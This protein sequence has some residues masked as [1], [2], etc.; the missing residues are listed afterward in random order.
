MG[1]A[2]AD[3]TL[4]CESKFASS[5]ASACKQIWAR[6]AGGEWVQMTRGLIKATHVMHVTPIDADAPSLHELEVIQHNPIQ[7]CPLVRRVC[8]CVCV[9][10]RAPHLSSLC[11]FS[12]VGGGVQPLETGIPAPPKKK[13]KPTQHLDLQLE[14]Y[15]TNERGLHIESTHALC[16]LLLC[17]RRLQRCL[18][19]A[20]LS[21]CVCVCMC[22]CVCVCAGR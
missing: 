10:A 20:Y 7:A 8:V 14:E 5:A 2:V 6:V 15:K 13:Q 16:G 12:F 1:L 21:V 22:V 11:I 18:Q 3:T 9:C 17:Y 4:T 19:S